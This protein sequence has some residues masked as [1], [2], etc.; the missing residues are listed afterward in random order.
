[1]SLALY[2][3]YR[4]AT[5]AEL[6]GQEH[7]AEPLQQALRNGRINHAY[8]FSGP[9]GCGKTSSARILARSL[10]CEKGPTPDPCGECDSCVALGPSG[11]GHIDVIEIDAASHGGVDDA[12]DLRE[13]AFF[14]PVSARFKV[15]IIDE[16]HMVTREGFNALLKLVEEPPP[17]LKFVFAT[18]EP[19]KVIGTIRSRT[20]HYPFRL[21]PP[22]VLQDLVEEI[23]RAEDVP[24]ETSALPL[25]VRAGAG[26]ARDTL[27]ILDQLL[28][29]SDEKGITYARAVSLLGYT[30]SAL[31]DEVIAAFAARDG[32][33]V[34]ASIDRV[35]ES[36]QDP[37]RFTADLLER[38][39]DLVILSNVPEAGGTGLLNVPPDELEAMRRQA[40]S[41]GPGELTRAADLLHTGLTEMRGATSPRLLLELICARILLPAAYEDEASMFARLDALERR[42][43]QGG[44]AG[45]TQAFATVPP[46]ATP[47]QGSPGQGAGGQGRGAAAQ[48]RGDHTPPS[49][50]GDPTSSVNPRP[51]TTPPEHG[52]VDNPATP[53]T[54][55][56]GSVHGSPRAGSPGS[57]QVSP[58]AGS[59]GSAHGSPRGGSSGS[60]PGGPAAAAPAPPQPSAAG[61]TDFG[62]IQRLWPD[63]VEA[64]KQKSRATWMVIMSGVQ[65]VSLDGKVLTLGF[66]AEGRRLGF[67]NG[68]R[69]TV[70]REVFKERMGV[71]WR[72]ETVVGGGGGGGGSGGGRGPGGGGRPG[73]GNGPN[74]GFGSAQSAGFGSGGGPASSG[75]GSAPEAQAPQPAAQASRP[76]TNP[77]PR[78]ANGE[79]P[80]QAD[81]GPMPPPPD[82]PPPP[83]E[84]APV[85]ESDEV[86]PEGDA[87][88]DGNEAEMNGMA[89]IQ[90]ELGGQVIR[91]I[92]TSQ[93]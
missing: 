83:P 44:G 69:D 78:P 76:N 27:S 52:S 60:A 39:R 86:D 85:D 26:S 10:N 34:F 37:R 66:D 45:M 4:P 79:A 88:A 5:F 16:A 71:D 92:D 19:E 32:A 11:T 40:P 90:R 62:T 43:S 75:F 17:H 35:V 36:G 29:G 13:R 93:A 25:A 73:A 48:M 20:H 61:G 51:S 21:I 74:G 38:V 80:R 68:G 56:S 55:S 67:V 65:P 72:I 91:E 8:L 77:V 6:K 15:Y 57:A 50:G 63:V 12:R 58:S 23:L 87:D 47:G 42:A 9:R 22:G 30:D 64:V 59:P 82:D 28:A 81:P 3:K 18:T 24:Y 2:R 41:M 33:A 31:L 53:S 89:L 54:G 14:A 7:V 1:M 49:Q 70:L 84:P 46:P